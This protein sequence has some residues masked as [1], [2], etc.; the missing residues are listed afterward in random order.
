MAK[1]SNRVHYMKPD[2]DILLAFNL[3]LYT[4]Y[5]VQIKSLTKDTALQE[6]YTVVWKKG[7]IIS[8]KIKIIVDKR[9]ARNV[10]PTFDTF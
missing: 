5:I 10:R 8:C 4:S 9:F 7:W 1:I 6:T 2:F 3:F